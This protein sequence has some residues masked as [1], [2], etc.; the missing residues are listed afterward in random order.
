MGKPGREWGKIKAFFVD[1]D[2]TLTDGIYEYHDDGHVSKRFHTKDM[3]A[4]HRLEE[5]GYKIFIATGCQDQATKWRML[6]SKKQIVDTG[7]R[8]LPV[9]ESVMAQNGLSWDEVAFVGDAEVD[10]E[11]IE[12]AAFS[13][14]PTD[15]IA[16]VREIV[17]YRS[18]ILGGHGAFH[19][20]AK[21]FCQITGK[22]WLPD[23]NES[24]AGLTASR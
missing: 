21:F 5:L 18:L 20:I 4:L 10:L 12:K 23:V 11:C 22:K 9:V 16:E 19:D 2:G 15:A 17:S 1:C 6:A 8:K 13:A 3:Y 14:C 7:A 24:E